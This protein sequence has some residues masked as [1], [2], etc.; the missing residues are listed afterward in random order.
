MSSPPQDEIQARSLRDPEAFWAHQAQ[1]LHWHVKPSRALAL[2]TRKLKSGV[3]YPSF[4]WFPDGEISTS[5]N[6]VDRHVRSGHGSS[7]AII[8]DSPVTGTKMKY[9]YDELLS[10][11]GTLA[12]VLQ[13][14][15]VKKGDVVLVYSKNRT[16]SSE[17]QADCTKCR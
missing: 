11:V 13:E 10:E 4:S 17:A 15:G 16:T 9:T 3:S 8:W 6:C 12:G 5:F 7:I 14:E 2:T 1:Q